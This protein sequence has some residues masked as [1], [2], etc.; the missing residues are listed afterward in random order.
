VIVERAERLQEAANRAK[1]AQVGSGQAAVLATH[2]VRLSRAVQRLDVSSA[3]LVAL[4]GAAVAPLAGDRRPV[5]SALAALDGAAAVEVAA[6][7]TGESAVGAI[8]HAADRLERDAEARWRQLCDACA[9]LLSREFVASMARINAYR[10]VATEAQSLQ[11][12]LQGLIGG[13]TPPEASRIQRVC[14]LRDK[15]QRLLESL[16]SAIPAKF[17]PLLQR[18]MSPQGLSLSDVTED[19]LEWIRSQDLED[20]FCLRLR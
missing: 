1:L 9:P 14:D 16:Q 13:R 7:A 4:P 3:A 15:L 10:A 8:E 20:T 2:L 5:E 11:D 12:S 17:G 6:S 18:S 19:F